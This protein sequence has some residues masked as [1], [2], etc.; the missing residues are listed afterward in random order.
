M[1]ELQN[2]SKAFAGRVVIHPTDLILETGRTTALLGQ[3]GSGKS[4][5]LRMMVGLIQP[6]G[7]AVRFDGAP[8]TPE[9]ARAARRRIG[10]VIQDGGLFPHLTAEENVALVARFLRWPATRIAQ[11]LEEL[12]DLTRFPAEGLRRYPSQLSGGQRQRVGLMRAL[13]L[14]PPLL[15]L[16]EPLG[17]LDPMIRAELQSDLRAIFR[18]LGKTVVLVT[19]DIGEAGYLADRI[20]LMR[21]GRIVQAGPLTELLRHPAEPFVAQFINAQRSPLDFLESNEP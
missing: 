18:A 16:D 14:D 5:L 12:L 19:H 21:D 4:T 20:A 10:Y 2:I 6:D 11:R 7:G 9:N 17:A 8:L 15:L 3:S 13:M 1:L